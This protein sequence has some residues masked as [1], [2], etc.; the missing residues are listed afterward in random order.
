MVA[1]FWFSG[2]QLH[3]ETIG[4]YFVPNPKGSFVRLDL[5]DGNFVVGSLV[6]E[7]R[8]GVRL[9][10]GTGALDFER[11]RIRNM[12]KVEEWE[13]ADGKYADWIIP[14]SRRLLWTK[15][16]RLDQILKWIKQKTGIP[17]QETSEHTERIQKN[18]Q[19]SFEQL[20]HFQF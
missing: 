14:P 18:L 16:N 15:I 3:L 4:D 17:I 12:T 11:N 20:K 1:A 13:I 2:I 8:E 19:K 6:R 10:I 5:S 9:R 7:T